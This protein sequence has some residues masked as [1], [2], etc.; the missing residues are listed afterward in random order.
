MTISLAAVTAMAITGLVPTGIAAENATASTG[1]VV[2]RLTLIPA[3]EK[4]IYQSVIAKPVQRVSKGGA[5]TQIGDTL[6]PSVTSRELPANAQEVLGSGHRYHYAKLQ[7]GKL[8]IVEP[9][10]SI[11]VRVIESQEK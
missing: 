5:M 4:A 3:Q 9:Q 11:I 7:G 10:T 1:R 2:H 6:S 8:L